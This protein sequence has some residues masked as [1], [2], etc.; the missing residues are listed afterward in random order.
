IG[1][2][3][4]VG[5][6]GEL[7]VTWNDYAANTIAFNRSFDGGVTWDKQSVVANKVI[8]FDIRIPAESFRGALVYPACDVDRSSGPHRGRLVCSWMDLAGNGTTDIF[9]SYSDNKGST[10]SLPSPAT[11][12][13]PFAVDR[14][15]HWLSTHPT[16]GVVNGASYHNRT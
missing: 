4:F 11:E 7:Y 14:L 8:P 15:N 13:L 10:W 6:N 2:I 16:N 5:T 9:P 1:A 12:Q 3:P